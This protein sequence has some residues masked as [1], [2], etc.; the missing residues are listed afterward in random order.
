MRTSETSKMK[1]LHL[2][3]AEYESGFTLLELTLVI[4]I[5][6]I[7]FGVVFFGME[8]VIEGGRLA[9][10]ARDM[11][12]FIT[13]VRTR[14][15]C[16]QEKLYIIY[17][18]EEGMARVCTSLSEIDSEPDRADCFKTERGI[19]MTALIIAGGEASNKQKTV[20]D[21]SSMG[22]IPSHSVT[23]ANDSQAMT[24]DVDGMLGIAR[25]RE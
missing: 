1:H 6:T 11:C 2:K 24:V 14:A 20:I 23:L 7:L 18:P 21:V 13:D 9:S 22:Y 17:M 3:Y 4:T 8:Q 15:V 5:L 25:I 10:S 12:S 16:R 19:R